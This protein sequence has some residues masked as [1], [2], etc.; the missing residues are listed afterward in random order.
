M[1]LRLADW[2]SSLILN[3]KPNTKQNIVKEM[4]SLVIYCMKMLC[5]VDEFISKDY[6]SRTPW[7]REEE[8]CCCVYINVWQKR[9]SDKRRFKIETHLE[10]EKNS[11]VLLLTLSAIDLVVFLL[12]DGNGC[13][14]SCAFP[15]SSVYN[16]H[17]K[18]LLL[19]TN[20]HVTA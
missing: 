16:E 12:V 1:I 4:K 10:F 19:P 9:A 20:I 14:Q 3:N 6:P 18:Q 17:G 5:Q 8:S 15:C 7:K 13:K 2:D 11:L